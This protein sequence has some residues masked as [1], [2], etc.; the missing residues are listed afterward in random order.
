MSESRLGKGLEALIRPNL[1]KKVKVSNKKRSNSKDIISKISLKSIVP[2]S[3]QPRQD[4]N[5]NAIIELQASIKEKGIITRFYS[6]CQCGSHIK[7]P[8]DLDFIFAVRGF[9]H[10]E[11]PKD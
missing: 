3:N 6:C 4:F 7:N 5:E 11:K 1:D 9:Y 10:L 2:N 8:T